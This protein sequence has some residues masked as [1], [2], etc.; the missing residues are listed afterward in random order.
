MR[1]LKGLGLAV[2]ATTLVTAAAC[3]GDDDDDHADL[4]LHIAPEDATAVVGTS[5]QFTAELHDHHADEETDV[6]ATSDW[7]SSNTAVAS[8]GATTGLVTTLSSGQTLIMVMHDDLT[9][10]TTLT[11]SSGG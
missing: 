11:V 7:S 6:T 3:S 10:E 5:I 1:I 9:A 2:L 4:E 8:V